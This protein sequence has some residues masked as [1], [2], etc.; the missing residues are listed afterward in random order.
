MATATAAPTTRAG[1]RGLT[2]R[3][4]EAILGWVFALPYVIHFVVLDVGAILFAFGLSLFETDLLT[5]LNFLG[6]APTNPCFDNS[7]VLFTE[8]PLFYKALTNT[9]LY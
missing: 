2:Q 6:G 1:S 4:V 7:R 9:A 3:R 5:G 8:E